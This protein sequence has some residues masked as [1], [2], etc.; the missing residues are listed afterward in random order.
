MQRKVKLMRMRERVCIAAAAAAA[1]NGA[2]RY[3]IDRRGTKKLGNLE[4]LLFQ[5]IRD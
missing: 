4:V 2:V 1:I 3:W 5:R